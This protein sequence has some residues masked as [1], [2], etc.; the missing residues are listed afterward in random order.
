MSPSPSSSATL[1]LAGLL[2]GR[3]PPTPDFPERLER[4]EREARA[5]GFHLKLELDGGRFGLLGD[6]V[7]RAWPDLAPEPEQ[8]LAERIEDLLHAFP[9][10]SSLFSTL[11]S[12]TTRGTSRTRTLFAVRPDGRVERAEERDV[13]D[14][15]VE[16]S[17]PPSRARAIAPLALALLGLGGAFAFDVLGVRT[18]V[19]SFY[20]P[21]TAW[22]VTA[23]DLEDF[24]DTIELE[25]FRIETTPM[26]VTMS[27]RRGA[28]FPARSRAE[29]LSRP[30][31]FE[32]LGERLVVEA[33]LRGRARLV[34]FLPDGSATEEIAVSID[35]LFDREI[36]E[37]VVPHDRLRGATRMHLS[38]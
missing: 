11:R 21:F 5:A 13:L 37:L 28:E 7:A 31:S 14:R 30:E 26:R 4:F 24:G 2:E 6:D 9:D 19:I 22:R 29:L 1:Q 25:G 38:W 27:L 35:G 32:S 12:T 20:L 33:L 16:V 15:P 18:R 34:G 17:K 10:R 23:V 3:V 36:I 8:D